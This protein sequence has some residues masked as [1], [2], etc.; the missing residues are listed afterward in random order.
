MRSLG[1]IA[2]QVSIHSSREREEKDKI[3]VSGMVGLRVS[4][5]SSREREEKDTRSVTCA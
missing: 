3:E 2:T 4:I 5:H 1:D